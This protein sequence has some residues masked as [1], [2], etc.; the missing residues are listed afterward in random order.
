M[1]L[2]TVVPLHALPA[3]LLAEQTRLL[4]SGAQFRLEHILSAEH[5]SATG[6]WYDQAQAEWVV[7]LAGSA[8]LEFE[9][10]MLT[11]AAGDALL[12][13]AHLKHRVARSQA[14]VWLALHFDA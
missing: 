3:A 2:P 1:S 10:G 5:A 14:A 12:I 9:D 7:L 13:P 6:F 4:A 8:T 11:L